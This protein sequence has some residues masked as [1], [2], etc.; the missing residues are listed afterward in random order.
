[1]TTLTRK[2]SK[3]FLFKIIIKT[4]EPN[5]IHFSK[6]KVLNFPQKRLYKAKKYFGNTQFKNFNFF[7]HQVEFSLYMGIVS[8]LNYSI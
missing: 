7:Y 8:N 1:M 6:K 4:H 5:L 2:F 3:T